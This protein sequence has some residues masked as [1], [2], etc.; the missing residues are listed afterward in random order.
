M[1]QDIRVSETRL[2]VNS[3]MIAST[4]PDQE[5][6]NHLRENWNEF[7]TSIFPFHVATKKSGNVE[8]IEFLQQQVAAGPLSVR[9]IDPKMA[10]K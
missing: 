10:M 6:N 4:P 9:M 8:A 5:S 7:V 2:L 1:R 3:I